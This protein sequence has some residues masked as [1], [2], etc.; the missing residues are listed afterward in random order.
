MKVSVRVK[1]FTIGEFVFNAFKAKGYAWGDGE[2]EFEDAVNRT[3]TDY[4]LAFD[5]AIYH[6]EVEYH[7]EKV[8]QE[9]WGPLVD[10]N[11]FFLSYY[12]K[13]KKKRRKGEK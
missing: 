7:K 8:T 12:P 10:I 11:E 9:L 2:L 4:V 3:R 5:N 1:D 13:L 6:G